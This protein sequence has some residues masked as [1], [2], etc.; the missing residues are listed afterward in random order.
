MRGPN[1]REGASGDLVIYADAVR[2]TASRATGYLA[3]EP[4]EDAFALL[5]APDILPVVHWGIFNPLGPTLATVLLAG[6]PGSGE[7][8]LGAVLLHPFSPGALVYGLVPPGEEAA[9]TAVEALFAGNGRPDHPLFVGLPSYVLLVGLG[10]EDPARLEACVLQ[11]AAQAAPVDLDELCDLLERHRGNPWERES[12]A[13]VFGPLL[14]GLR[15]QAPSP[16]WPPT[17]AQLR[18]WWRAVTDADQ[19]MGEL[20][21]M[22]IAWEGS[23]GFFGEQQGVSADLVGS[24]TFVSRCGEGLPDWRWK[25]IAEYLHRILFAFAD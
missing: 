17:E 20:A 8:L 6:V 9:W 15:G 22:G 1:T 18:R 21:S 10:A 5:R 3:A 11:A 25:T 2:C 23:I 4:V 19:I 24:I 7:R 12:P 16:P 13:R 14:A